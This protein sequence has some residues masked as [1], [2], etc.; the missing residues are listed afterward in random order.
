MKGDILNIFHEKAV[1]R[2][3]QLGRREFVGENGPSPAFIR[4]LVEPGVK[5][6][7]YAEV[8]RCRAPKRVK[9]SPVLG[10]DTSGSRQGWAIGRSTR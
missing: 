3:G 1:S 10:Q 9:R 6:S 2:Q 4:T 5:D 7:A 8:C